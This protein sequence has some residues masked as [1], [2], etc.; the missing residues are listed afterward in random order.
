MDNLPNHRA[1]NQEKFRVF[2]ERYPVIIPPEIVEHILNIQKQADAT[3]AS[4]ELE[5]VTEDMRH[6][7]IGK[8]ERLYQLRNTP[9][10]STDEIKKL[11]EDLSDCFCG[12]GKKF[13]ECHGV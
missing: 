6:H 3:A 11:E 9:D 10:A 12:S 7:N 13:S 2:L 4:E 5:P 8:Y 1:E